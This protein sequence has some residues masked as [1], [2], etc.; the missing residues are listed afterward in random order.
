MRTAYFA[1][2]SME[3]KCRKS[4]VY[5]DKCRI[6]KTRAMQACQPYHRIAPV[7]KRRTGKVGR[8]DALRA[9]WPLNEVTTAGSGFLRASSNEFPK[10]N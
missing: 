5:N 3:Q 4:N 10:E 2:E 7:E 6:L 9:Q 1:F 8:D